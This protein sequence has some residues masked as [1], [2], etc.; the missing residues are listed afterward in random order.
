MDNDTNTETIKFLRD[1]SFWS[2]EQ[3]EK[4]GLR[5]FKE[6]EDLTPAEEKEEMQIIMWIHHI[7]IEEDAV[8][9]L[10]ETGEWKA[11]FTKAKR[12]PRLLWGLPEI[13][14]VMG[15]ALEMIRA[16]AAVLATPATDGDQGGEKES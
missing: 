6:G 4:I 10:I 9:Q 3:I 11:A 15:K 14:G 13:E 7:D 16:G 5:M 12:N 8:E 1:V 2:C